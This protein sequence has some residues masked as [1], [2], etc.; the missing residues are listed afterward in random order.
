MKPLCFLTSSSICSR[1]TLRSKI[2]AFVWLIEWFSK[3][4]RSSDGHGN[5]YLA[6][7]GFFPQFKSHNALGTNDTKTGDVWRRHQSRCVAYDVI[8][9][10]TQEA[11]D[12]LKRKQNK[13]TASSWLNWICVD[14]NYWMSRS[15]FVDVSSRSKENS[16][17]KTKVSNFH[18]I[19][20]IVYFTWWRRPWF[21]DV[22][23][24]QGR[25]ANQVKS[26]RK[27]RN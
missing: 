6:S 10:Q 20:A 12:T 9:S 14:S 2:R 3:E 11:T 22:M 25:S 26:Q 5:W 4:E 19:T 17:R 27:V 21:S 23:P 13:S 24:L 7:S 16:N 8:I 1:L 15:S 18:V